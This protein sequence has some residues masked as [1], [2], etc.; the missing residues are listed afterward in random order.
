MG[1]N[2]RMD[3]D[4]GIFSSSPGFPLVIGIGSLVNRYQISMVD[5][6][7]LDFAFHELWVT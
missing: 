2:E 4:G 7:C 1:Q 6:I 5:G 3:A